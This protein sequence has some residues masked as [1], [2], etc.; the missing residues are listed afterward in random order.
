MLTNKKFSEWLNYYKLDAGQLIIAAQQASVKTISTVSTATITTSDLLPPVTLPPTKPTV[1]P[2]D[3]T[4]Q[5]LTDNTQG[6]KFG[7]PYPN[8]LRL[9]KKSDRSILVNW[10]PP[11]AP[12]G[13]T[14]SIDYDNNFVD[15]KE[16]VVNV[17]TYNLFL[18]NDIY[19]SINGNQPLSILIQDI[20][21][22]AV[23]LFAF[24]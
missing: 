17:Q 20:D 14:Q 23:R 18:N 24:L 15:V 3:I 8:N 13:Q 21:L 19:K 9:E 2:N 16:Q 5:Y 10:D 1:N 4:K 7:V 6:P 22:N 12:L 11:T